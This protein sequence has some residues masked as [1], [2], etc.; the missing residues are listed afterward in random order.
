MLT[1]ENLLKLLNKVLKLKDT[2]VIY[3]D[4]KYDCDYCISFNHR[5]DCIVINSSYINTPLEK[6][7]NTIMYYNVKDRKSFKSNG[8]ELDSF[9]WNDIKK[10][11]DAIIAEKHFENTFKKYVYEDL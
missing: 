4:T 10:K 9:E 8:F 11:L 5:K 6:V 3:T 1:K 2:I 7:I